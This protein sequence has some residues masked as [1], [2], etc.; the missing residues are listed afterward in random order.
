MEAIAHHLS[1]D[2][3]GTPEAFIATLLNKLPQQQHLEVLTEL[4]TQSSEIGERIASFINAACEWIFQI[5][6]WTGEYE[7]LDHY[8]KAIRYTETVRPIVQRHKRSELA[9]RSYSKTILRH[10]AVPFE[11]A[12]PADVQPSVWTWGKGQSVGGPHND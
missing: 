5:H 7:S 10:W 6:L 2:P 9:K 3:E 1:C 11:Q 8:R 12:L 4:L